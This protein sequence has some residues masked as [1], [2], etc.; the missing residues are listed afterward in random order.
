M[1][2]K[3]IIFFTILLISFNSFSKEKSPE[4]TKKT[5]P[6]IVKETITFKELTEFDACFLIYRSAISVNLK[7]MLRQYMKFREFECSKFDETLKRASIIKGFA[8]KNSK[9]YQAQKK[10]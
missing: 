9:G 8:L 5:A 6:P 1:S 3:K 4:E 10:K 2:I 7:D